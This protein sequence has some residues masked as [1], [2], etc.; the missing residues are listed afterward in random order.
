MKSPLFSLNSHSE[1]FSKYR[2]WVLQNPFLMQLKKIDWVIDG[3]AAKGR[4]TLVAGSSGAGKSLL[5]H[6][7][8]QRSDNP[9]FRVT[10]GKTVYLVGADASIDDVQPRSICF[11]QDP[12]RSLFIAPLPDTLTFMTDAGFYH[13]LIGWVEDWK[14]DGVDSIIFDT[15]A[16]FHE[17]DLFNPTEAVRTM[18]RFRELADKSDLAVILITHSKKGTINNKRYSSEDISDS[19]IFVSKSDLAFAIKVDPE[20]DDLYELQN[21]KNRMGMKIKPIRYEVKQAKDSKG[22]PIPGGTTFLRSDRLFSFEEAGSEKARK[23]E[24]R[25]ATARTLRDQGKTL[26]EI[27]VILGVTRQRVDQL[28]KPD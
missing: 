22:R 28:L 12:I 7:L 23:A 25:R 3:F 6:Y 24:D 15:I 5:T 13:S 17:G 1:E 19:R 27:G 16:D 21:P 20:T 11:G 4:I 10:K 9:F 18:K 2:P 14:A 8:F 26:Q